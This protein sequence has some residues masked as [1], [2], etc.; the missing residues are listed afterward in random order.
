MASTLQEEEVQALPYHELTDDEQHFRLRL[1]ASGCNKE[2]SDYVACQRSGKGDCEDQAIDVEF[3][4]S[5]KLCPRELL[6]MVSDPSAAAQQTLTQ[7]MTHFTQLQNTQGN[8]NGEACKSHFHRQ[9]AC[10]QQLGQDHPSCSIPPLLCATQVSCTPGVTQAFTRCLGVSAETDYRSDSALW[11]QLISHSRLD[12]DGA[13][14]DHQ[15]KT[16]I[17]CMNTTPGFKECFREKISNSTS[18]FQ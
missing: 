12:K 7:C 2:V 5:E 15:R 16:M 9:L 18:V 14:E 6:A 11:D 3:C 13:W 17:R 4:Y 1:L 10:F 8:D